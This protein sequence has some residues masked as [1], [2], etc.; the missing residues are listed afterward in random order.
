MANASES[1]SDEKSDSSLPIKRV[2][3]IMKITA[4]P[5]LVKIKGKVNYSC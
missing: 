1:V 5:R 2:R 4:D 3:I